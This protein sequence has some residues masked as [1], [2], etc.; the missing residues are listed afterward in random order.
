MS[1]MLLYRSKTEPVKRHN[2]F[3]FANFNLPKNNKNIQSV[4]THSRWR[5][6]IY[7]YYYLYVDQCEEKLSNH[8]KTNQRS[9]LAPKQIDFNLKAFIPKY[10]KSIVWALQNANSQDKMMLVFRPSPQ[11]RIVF[12]FSKDI[13][14]DYAPLLN[15]RM[16]MSP[17]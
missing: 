13:L 5:L 17:N 6:R 9:T 2:S 16:I 8:I 7:F 15:G 11:G 1:F 4:Y 14:R 12:I 10:F 3:F